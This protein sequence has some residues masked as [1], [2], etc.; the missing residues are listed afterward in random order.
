MK[1]L[2]FKITIITKKDIPFTID[3]IRDN[4][5]FEVYQAEYTERLI[6]VMYKP[7]MGFFLLSFIKDVKKVLRKQYNAIKVERLETIKQISNACN[8]Q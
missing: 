3:Q 1:E 6:T 4:P 2:Y 5:T 8:R 7:A